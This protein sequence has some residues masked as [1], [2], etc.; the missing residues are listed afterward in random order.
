MPD[1]LGLHGR[2]WVQRTHIP[3]DGNSEFPAPD[4]SE[5]NLVLQKYVS[6]SNLILVLF[7]S[8]HLLTKFFP[9]AIL[10]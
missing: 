9:D 3:Q 6:F 5:Q 8:S 4:S 10:N 2:R 1:Q 7:I